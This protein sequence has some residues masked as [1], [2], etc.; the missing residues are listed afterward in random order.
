MQPRQSNA[1]QK[2]QSVT[3]PDAQVV[4]VPPEDAVNVESTPDTNDTPNTDVAIADDTET[5]PAEPPVN[6]AAP[7]PAPEL[8]E[9]SNKLFTLDELTPLATE[10]MAVAKYKNVDM[11]EL[12]ECFRVL[13]KEKKGFIELKRFVDLVSAS[14]SGFNEDEWAEFKK[15]A[16]S[17]KEPDK[18]HYNEYVLNFKEVVIRHL[19]KTVNK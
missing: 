10:L 12:V 8:P 4:N 6:E 7:E 14:G 3:L 9:V 15:F 11:L 2:V 17:E 13:D 19:S 1:S 16:V 5:A 18:I